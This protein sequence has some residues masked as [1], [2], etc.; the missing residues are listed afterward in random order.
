MD[1]WL[2]SPSLLNPWIIL[3]L[4]LKSKVSWFAKSLSYVGGMGQKVS[5]LLRRISSSLVR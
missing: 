4:L 5:P 2:R 3:N 1:R